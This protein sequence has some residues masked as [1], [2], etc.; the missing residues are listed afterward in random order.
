[1]VPSCDFVIEKKVE[2][3]GRR[4][5]VSLSPEEPPETGLF[6]LAGFFPPGIRR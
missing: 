6:L 4:F 5:W 1:M 2:N 3:T